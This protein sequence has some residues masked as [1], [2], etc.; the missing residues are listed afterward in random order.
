MTNST[1]KSALILIKKKKLHDSDVNLISDSFILNI[2]KNTGI[3]IIYAIVLL[4]MR[5]K[6]LRAI[7]SGSIN[8]SL[9]H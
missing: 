4:F 6:S 1:L 9:A 2:K 7:Y 3:L 8:V 5:K